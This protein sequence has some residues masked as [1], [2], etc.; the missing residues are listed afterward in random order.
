[1]T[2]FSKS[3]HKH[4]QHERQVLQRL[5]KYHLYV[6]PEKCEF[7]VTEVAFLGFII[8]QGQVLMDSRK[9]QAVKD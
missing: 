3:R 7:H 8:K 1:M 9:T 5:L 4:C 6:K 2:F